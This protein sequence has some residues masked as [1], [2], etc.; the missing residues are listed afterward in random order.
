[1]GAADLLEQS[2]AHLTVRELQ[3]DFDKLMSFKSA[4]DLLADVLGQPP[5]C[6]GDRCFEGVACRS[7]AFFFFAGKTHQSALAIVRVRN[8]DLWQIL[9]EVSSG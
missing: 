8:V 9:R 5:L 3:F 6:D 4:I 7:Q 2:F 1:M